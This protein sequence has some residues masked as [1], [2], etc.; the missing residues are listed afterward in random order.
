MSLRNWLRTHVAPWLGRRSHALPAGVQHSGPA[1][2]VVILDGTMSSLK[3]GRQTHA[4]QLYHLL[5]EMRGQSNL[6]IHYE[7]GIQW[8][9]W[10]DTLDVAQG[11]G[12][13]RQIER[14]YGALAS[15]YRVGDRI[16][17][18]GYSRGAY[19]VRSLAGM[20]DRVGLLKAD[21]ATQRA[22]RQ[23]YRYYRRGEDGPHAQAFRRRHCHA[24][25][26]SEAL[27]VWDTVK[28]LGLRV[29]ILWRWSHVKHAFHN[30]A[31]GASIKHG[32][33]ALALDETRKA[34]APVLWTS[35]PKWSGHME[36]VWFRGTHGDIGGQIHGFEP[37]RPLANIPL[38]WMLKRLEG[39]GLPLPDGWMARFPTDPTAPS[40]GKWR[41]WSKLFLSRVPRVVGADPSERL[42]ASVTSTARI[43]P[44]I[45]Q[46]G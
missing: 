20:V 6:T 10:S 39:C 41:G 46:S 31:L 7:P 18:A 13:N 27:A 11:R 9:D 36:Q 21:H 40:M 35:P 38:V 17:F 4:G 29:P 25:V 14:A 26:E 5:G 12:I 28:A 34:Y 1:I 37:A 15:R 23:A 22:V 3:S 33:H 44:P 43:P 24:E 16:F 42:Y 32:F 19:A 2:H 8:T 30:H 45:A